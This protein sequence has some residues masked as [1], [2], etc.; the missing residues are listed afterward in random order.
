MGGPARNRPPRAASPRQWENT[1]R[2]GWRDDSKPDPTASMT[3]S[4]DTSSPPRP[5]RRRKS[6]PRTRWVLVGS[7]VVT[8]LLYVVPYGRWLVYP[9]TL[10]STLAHEMGHGVAALLVGGSFRR[11]E[12]WADGSGVAHWRGD[13][14]ALGLA[15]VAMGG[16]VGPA[17]VAGMAFFFGRTPTGARA[18][19]GSVALILLVAELLV[20]RGV[21]AFVFVALVATGLVLAARGPSPELC[22]WVLVFLAV[23]LALS[24]FSRGDYLFTPVAR[25]SAG[26]LPSDVAQIAAALPLPYWF[27]GGVC[28]GVS[29]LVLAMGVRAYWRS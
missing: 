19:L 9:C 11:L 23:Q 15:V 26:T 12:M 3:P 10:L 29:I 20:V 5:P 27:W 22:Q 17:L 8:A 2:V 4:T 14:G 24:V 7:L 13:V 18:T 28:A 1:H 6:G 21:F 16:L 25:T